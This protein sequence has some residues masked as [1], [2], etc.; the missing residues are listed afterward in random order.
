MVV[1]HWFPAGQYPSGKPVLGI[2]ERIV[3]RPAADSSARHTPEA[4]P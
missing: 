3:G 1:E 4:Q 2:A